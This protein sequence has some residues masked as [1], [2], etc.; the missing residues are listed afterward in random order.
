MSNHSLY[1]KIAQFNLKITFVASRL[2]FQQKKIEDEIRE[3]YQ[4]FIVTSRPDTIHYSLQF[5]DRLKYE[6]LYDSKTKLN[7]HSI[8]QG[9]L[10]KDDSMNVFY[11]ISLFQFQYLIRDIVVKLLKNTGGF[12]IHASGNNHHGSAVIFAG[13]SGEG[14]S[15]AMKLLHPAYPS[16]AD[17]SIIIRLEKGKYIAYQTPMTEKEDWVVKGAKGYLL[18]RVFFPVKS[19]RFFFEK[20]TDK[21]YILKRILEEFWTRNESYTK[22]QLQ[23]IFAFVASMDEVYNVHFAKDQKKF[24]RL[25][26]TLD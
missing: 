11:Q 24:I 25:F 2:P 14:K 26:K 15:T 16:I 7:F 3:Y 10:E 4:H 17:D 9:N 23:D 13:P 20:V 21:E 18:K 6:V 8:Y 22:A 1:L 19:K 12:V 5:T